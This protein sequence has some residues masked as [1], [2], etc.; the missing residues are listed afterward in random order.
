MSEQSTRTVDLSVPQ[1]IG[2][3][4]A[5]ATA[6]ALSSRLGVL[7]TITGAALASIVSAVVAAALAGWLHR[8]RELTVRREPTRLRSVVIGALAL[9][10]VGVA[11]HAGLDLVLQ[12]LPSDAFAT[13][14]LAEMG[15]GQ[16]QA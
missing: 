5:A 15:L 3:S 11:F 8:A 7:G 12:D 9:G 10:L 2:G 1:L 16:G 6:A 4:V 13:R 14:L